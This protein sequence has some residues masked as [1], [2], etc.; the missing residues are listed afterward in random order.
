MTLT[1]TTAYRVT[2]PFSIRDADN[3]PLKILETI[4]QDTVKQ[5]S[6]EFTLGGEAFDGR[7]DFLIGAYYF[8]ETDDQFYPV[9][10]PSLIN[11]DGLEA[12]V[13]GSSSDAFIK[14]ESFA[15]FTQESFAI[16]DALDFTA[17][18][19]YT[20]DV[21]EVTPHQVPSPSILGFENVGYLVPYPDGT[22]SVCLGSDP[23]R[24][25]GARGL[26]CAGST[27][28]LFDPVLNR[29][30]DSRLTPM[31]T[32][33]YKWSPDFSTYV[34]YSQGYK[35]GGFNTRIIQPVYGPDS[36][37]GREFLPSFAPE[38]VTSYEVGAKVQLG[39]EFRLSTAAYIAK[40]DDIHIVVR[41]GVA[42]VVRNAG[43]ATIKGFEAEGQISPIPEFKV[44]FGVGYTDFGYD[45]FSAALLAGQAALEPGA[46]GR[47]D[48]DDMQA[49]TPKWSL[50]LG[51]SYEI[52]LDFATL[53]P[54]VDL[55]HRS[56]TYFDAP[57]TE[58]IAQGG[59][60]LLNASLR[61]ADVD[62]RWALAASVTN[63]TDKV[64][65]VSGNSS[66]TASSGYAE[67]TYAPPRMWSLDFTYKF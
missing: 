47:V 48:L 14:N 19:R 9:Y 51:A 6:Q 64:Y 53:T 28:Y 29:R 1:S 7:M 43:K 66:L 11:G 20:R 62:D 38:K 22:Q 12:Y 58:Q 10:L 37:T 8:R 21:K 31:A 45:S 60:E 16:T 52:D 3:T 54:R 55:S 59:Y 57:N 61:L 23:D 18:L 65:R 17:G 34:S 67:V 26:P 27:E 30:V 33:S 35:S 49:Y 2:K 36:P 44:D 56:K 24:A 15:L 5:F 32:L 39:R 46:L 41:E 25:T 40:Y 42:P 13:G 50:S 63:L 4:N